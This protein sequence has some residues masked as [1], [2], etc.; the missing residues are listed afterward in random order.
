AGPAGL[1]AAGEL[2][3]MGHQPVIFEATDRLGGMTSFGIPRYRLPLSV[4]EENGRFILDN[5]NIELRTNVVVGRDVLVADLLHSGGFS[6]V[7]AAV[8][9]HLPRKMPLEGR[10]LKGVFEG[11]DFLR[12]VACEKPTNHG[13]RVAVIGGGNVA[14]DAA[15]TSLRLGA[16][17]VLLVYRRGLA[18]MPAS[19]E[20]IHHA[21][22]EGIEFKLLT[23]PIKIIGDKTGWVKE[24]ECLKMELSEADESGR[25]QPIPIKDS[26]FRIEVSTVIMAIGQLPD[27]GWAKGLDGLAVTRLGTPVID[28]DTLSTKVDGLF[29]AGDLATGPGIAISAVESGIRAARQV[30]AYLN[31]QKV[32]LKKH[33]KQEVVNY[34]TDPKIDCIRR[35]DP[36]ALSADSRKTGF[37]QV[38]IAFDRQTAQEQARR[39]L[40]CFNNTVFNQEECLLCGGCVDV[41]PNY[42]LRLI[43][44]QEAGIDVE[45]DSLSQGKTLLIKDEERCIRCGLCVRH[46]PA[47]AIN[48]VHF[49]FEKEWVY[50]QR[51]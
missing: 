9:A 2:A 8:G 43:S 29:A 18:E 49:E 19:A 6:A 37:Q 25:R 10:D 47:G 11:V 32:C 1:A 14:M 3:M 26:E 22:E 40:N 51:N 17:H 16:N 23:D 28:K 39:C 45:Q 38:E 31:K 34:A 42:C 7:I 35:Q 48:M 30:D 21:R 5:S 33:L 27:N 44:P 24:I 20:E 12:E 46:C 15:R 13:K 41:C 50:E 36:P 4:I